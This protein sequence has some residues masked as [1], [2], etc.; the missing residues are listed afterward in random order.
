QFQTTPSSMTVIYDNTSPTV[1]ISVP[2]TAA[3]TWLSSLTQ[4]TGTAMDNYALRSSTGVEGR[5]FD[6]SASAYVST[7]TNDWTSLNGLGRGLRAAPAWTHN[8]TYRIEARATDKAGNVS[9]IYSTATFT[10]DQ[11]Q[12]SPEQP[13][14][15]PSSPAN[16]TYIK[17][18]TTV[19][20][21]A[22]DNNQ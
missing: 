9:P 2:S 16:S 3:Q 12:A 1:A 7:G 22:S 18:L 17:T 6:I 11:Y 15:A 20:G 19:Q 4:I 13:D 5:I 8:H 10:Y 21:T 14:S